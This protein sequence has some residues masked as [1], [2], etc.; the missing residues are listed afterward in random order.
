[1]HIDTGE[2]RC[3][4]KSW[5]KVRTWHASIPRRMKSSD[6]VTKIKMYL[7]MSTREASYPKCIT[8]LC[9]DVSRFVNRH[10]GQSHIISDRCNYVNPPLLQP[11]RVPSDYIRAR[12][13]IILLLVHSMT[14]STSGIVCSPRNGKM[15][16][17]SVIYYYVSPW[18]YWCNPRRMLS[19]AREATYAPYEVCSSTTDVKPVGCIVTVILR[20]LEPEHY[21]LRHVRLSWSVRRSRAVF[22]N[23]LILPLW[24]LSSD[25]Y[26]FL[27]TIQFPPYCANILLWRRVLP[28][29]PQKSNDSKLFNNGTIRK[30]SRHVHIMVARSSL[31]VQPTQKSGV[32]VQRGLHVGVQSAVRIGSRC[33]PLLHMSEWEHHMPEAHR[34]VSPISDILCTY[35]S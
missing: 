22:T 33:T 6:N 8:F 17:A 25:C 16:Y 26:T 29:W 27:C 20:P 11:H 10:V 4:G 31:I 7:L 18:A 3:S 1:M 21:V 30:R 23:D 5:L 24:K 15:I 14:L 34:V 13:V 9:A 35:T 32:V 19:I 28:L 2:I 12:R